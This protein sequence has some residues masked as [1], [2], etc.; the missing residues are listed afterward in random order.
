MITTNRKF[1][2]DKLKELRLNFNLTQAELGEMIGIGRDRICRYEK[3]EEP[4][5]ETLMRLAQALEVP[6]SEL[7][8]F[9]ART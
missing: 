4:R 3:G 7:F 6:A 1:D 8:Y 5:Y 9:K 2:G